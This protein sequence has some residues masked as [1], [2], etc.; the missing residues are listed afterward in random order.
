MLATLHYPQL[1][2]ELLSPPCADY[3]STATASVDCPWAASALSALAHLTADL[4]VQA[5]LEPALLLLAQVALLTDV[6]SALVAPNLADR[7]LPSDAVLVRLLRPA[8]D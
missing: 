7:Q 5:S 1:S 2:A 4:Q 3:S 6:A 8:M